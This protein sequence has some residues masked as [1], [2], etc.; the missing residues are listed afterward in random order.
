M[1]AGL[2][3]GLFGLGNGEAKAAATSYQVPCFPYNKPNYA[4]RQYVSGWGY[5]VAEDSCH[6]AGRAVFAAGNGVVKYSAR[7]PD[8]Y[9]WGNLI[10]IEHTTTSGGKVLSLYGHL[11]ND[12]KVRAGQTVFKGQRIGTVGPRG[13]QNGNWDPHVHFGIRIARYNAGTGSYDSSI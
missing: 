12:R 1:G 3:L 9:R 4:F 10:V 2:V 13:G 6:Q 11:G 7:T 5:H 8:S